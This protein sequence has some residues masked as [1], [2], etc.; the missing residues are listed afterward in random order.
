MDDFDVYLTPQ[1]QTKKIRS[2]FGSVERGLNTMKQILTP[3]R[4]STNKP[5][6]TWVRRRL[7]LP[8][9]MLNENTCRKQPMSLPSISTILNKSVIYSNNR[10]KSILS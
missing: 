8:S 2:I 3:K 4:L 5:R 7:L 1:R 9:E 10:S 6:K